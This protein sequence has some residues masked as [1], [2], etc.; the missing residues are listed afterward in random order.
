LKI[1]CH[2]LK[3]VAV[4]RVAIALWLY[5]IL[6]YLITSFMSIPDTKIFDNRMSPVD[7]YVWFSLLAVRK[8]PPKGRS[9]LGR[10]FVHRIVKTLTHA[11]DTTPAQ[12]L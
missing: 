1:I 12:I 4:G 8:P 11:N 7:F 6:K 2:F 3:F 9:P 10:D 5:L